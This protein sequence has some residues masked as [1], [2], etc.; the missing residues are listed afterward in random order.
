MNENENE[1]VMSQ[2]REYKPKGESYVQDPFAGS[3]VKQEKESGTKS[4]ET[5]AS[6]SETDTENNAQAISGNTIMRRPLIFV[7][8]A[9]FAVVVLIT[10]IVVGS[11]SA[12]R[13]KA[14][15]EQHA[16]ELL[17]EEETYVY[18]YSSDEIRDLRLAGYTGDEIDMY[19][20]DEW[21]VQDLVKSAEAARKAMYEEEILP[22]FNSASDEF[23]LLWRDTWVGQDDFDLGDDESFDYFEETVNVDYTKLDPKGH[24]LFIKY[25]LVNDSNACFMTVTPER[26]LELEESGNIV[27]R[28]KYTKTS[29]GAKV[30]I[31]ATEVIP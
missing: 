16:L 19:E 25:Y 20:A 31:S 3:E 12:K 17:E 11:S 18:R 28:I 2:G 7:G 4:E 24:Q 8:V 10:V 13:K 26:Y 9:V 14:E 22:Y 1:V 15:E 5:L 27:L 21:D 29:D 6:S 30:I 23:K